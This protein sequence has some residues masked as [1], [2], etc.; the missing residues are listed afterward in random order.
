[1]YIAFYRCSLIAAATCAPFAIVF[2]ASGVLNMTP[3]PCRAAGVPVI[4][5]RLKDNHLP[6][7]LHRK[8]RFEC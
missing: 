5:R 7:S 1:M 4:R 6:R 2:L 8:S 3:L